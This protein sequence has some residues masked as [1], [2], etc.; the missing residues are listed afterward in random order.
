MNNQ[1]SNLKS[2]LLS[3]FLIFGLSFSLSA[4][5][6]NE[7]KKEISGSYKVSKDYTLG[8]D[9]KYGSIDIVNWD[10]N[11]M[12]VVVEMIVKAS[13]E[14][15]ANKILDKID[16]DID[17]GSAG[18][19]FVTKIDLKSLSGKTS[20]EINYK[21]S[22][23]ASINVNL[24]QRYGSLFIEEV[25]GDAKIIVKYGSLKAHSLV[26]A[27]NKTNELVLA[28]SEAGIKNAGNLNAKVAYSEVKL[29]SVDSYSGKTSY[30]E[31]TVKNLTGKLATEVAYAE[32]VVENVE[33][34][35]ELVDISSAYGDVEVMMDSKA[36]Y[37]YNLETRYGSL[38]A[39]D[40]AEKVSKDD[41]GN[42]KTV[43]GKVGS[44]PY[45]KVLI[46]AKYA[47]L[48]VK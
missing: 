46:S 7:V 28:Y 39:P 2:I 8:I 18:V 40:G 30:S 43:E 34:G 42:H 26:N 38:D 4:Q 5:D 10:K 27:A 33:A 45:G 19:D 48:E 37:S 16:I 23:P 13:S 36:S 25:T 11:E 22:A 1:V 17:E 31:F 32:L 6:K 35:F 12:E 47:D 14:E 3:L 24:T 21:V 9:S 29:E 20:V 44:S 15:K 41:H